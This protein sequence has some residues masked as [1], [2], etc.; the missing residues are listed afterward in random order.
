MEGKMDREEFI[1]HLITSGE[2][3]CYCHINPPCG[4]C[5]DDVDDLYEEYLDEGEAE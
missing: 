5:T 4:F 2:Y 3:R 1:E